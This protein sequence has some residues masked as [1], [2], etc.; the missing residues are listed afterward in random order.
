VSG[1][2]VVF[3]NLTVSSGATYL[4]DFGDG[5][6]SIVPAPS[7]VYATSGTYN[8]ELKATNSCGSDSVT[9]PVVVFVVGIGRQYGG[10]MISA[11][12][13]PSNGLVSLN[14]D[15][16]KEDNLNII[17]SDIT[18]RTVYT[19]QISSVKRQAVQLDLSRLAEG[20][21]LL[22]V[23]GNDGTYSETIQLIK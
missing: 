8:V 21:Y 19:E 13:N 14:L 20:S 12:P 10:G 5:T 2:S 16:A 15:L 18:G 22:K 6:T 11:Y 9:N 7:H 4:W 1:A 23:Q 3:N 17:I